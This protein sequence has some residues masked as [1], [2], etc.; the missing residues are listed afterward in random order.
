MNVIIRHSQSYLEPKTRELLSTYRERIQS[1]L[2]ALSMKYSFKLPKEIA[3]QPRDLKASYA[4]ASRNGRFTKNYRVIKSY[5]VGVN[6]QLCMSEPDKGLSVIDHECAHI[7]ETL[8]TNKMT[9]HGPFWKELYE[10][11][12][13]I[14]KF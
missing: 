7:A 8:I 2:K 3:L 4:T 6:I 13:G 10:Y 14:E 1:V 9:N 5:T 11:C 12:L